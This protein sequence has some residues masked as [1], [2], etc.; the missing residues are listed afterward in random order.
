[1]ST[2]E[3]TLKNVLTVYSHSLGRGV[4]V[5]GNYQLPPGP[6]NQYMSCMPR[7]TLSSADRHRVQAANVFRNGEWKLL[8]CKDKV[9]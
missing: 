9:N 8:C 7:S 1:M 6:M 5:S 3:F 2:P 4:R